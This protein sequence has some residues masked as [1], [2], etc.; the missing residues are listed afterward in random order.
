MFQAL[1]HSTVSRLLLNDNICKHRKEFGARVSCKVRK[2]YDAAQRKHIQY[3]TEYQ[4]Q[5][6]K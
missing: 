6:G 5:S 3:R 4:T 1:N 2:L